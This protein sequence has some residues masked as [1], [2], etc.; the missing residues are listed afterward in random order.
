[1]PSI[2]KRGNSFRFTVSLGYDVSGRQIRKTTTY[3]PPRNI[4]E[5]KAQKLAEKAFYEFE[6]QCNGMTSLNENMRF[7]ALCDWY[8]E[9]FA[10]SERV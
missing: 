6:Q 1:M 2:E 5:S 3:T 7:G 10:P 8:F 9:N 4:S